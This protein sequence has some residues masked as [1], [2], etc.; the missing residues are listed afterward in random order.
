MIVGGAHDTK[1]TGDDVAVY[2]ATHRSSAESMRVDISCVLRLPDARPPRF[3]L[4]IERYATSDDAVTP[5]QH[6]EVQFTGLA[7]EEG[8]RLCLRCAHVSL[9]NA[10]DEQARKQFFPCAWELGAVREWDG[11]MQLDLH[12]LAEEPA[13]ARHILPDWILSSSVPLILHR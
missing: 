2:R 3:V 10:L 6:T 7:H 13:A 12:S 1:S 5:A 4:S 11:V 8:A 9:S